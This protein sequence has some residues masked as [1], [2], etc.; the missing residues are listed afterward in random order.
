VAGEEKVTVTPAFGLPKASV[1]RTTNG[2]ARAWPTT[3][4]WPS[5][6]TSARALA[7]PATT[8]TVAVSATPACPV[9]AA[10]RLRLPA[11]TSVTEKVPTPSASAG[12]AGSTAPG[13][14]EVR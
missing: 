2:A 13:S 8:S 11:P 5:P 4:V 7:A 1:A 9:S 14:L 12:E 6:E 10:V 3:P